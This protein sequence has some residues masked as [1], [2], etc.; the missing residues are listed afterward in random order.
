VNGLS[1]SSGGTFMAFNGSDNFTID[2]LD[3]DGNRA[4]RSCALFS[5][6]GGEHG[7]SV[8]IRSSRNGTIRNA[9][10]I[11]GCHDNV[12]LAGS[13]ASD[14]TTFP[15]NIN[16]IDSKFSNAFRN[17]VS[18]IEGWEIRF[19]GTCSGTF[20]GTCT[21]QMT[22]ANGGSPEAGIDWEPNPNSSASPSNANGMVDGCLISGNR[23]AGYQNHTVNGACNLTLQNSILRNNRSIQPQAPGTLIQN[24]YIRTSAGD[25]APRFG[26]IYMSRGQTSGSCVGTTTSAGRKSEVKDNFIDGD[27]IPGTDSGQDHIIYFGNFGDGTGEFKNNVATNSGETASGDWCRSGVA[28]GG[29][30]TVSGNTINGSTQSPNPGCP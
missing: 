19:L 6:G 14:T 20:S 16:F 18:V 8:Q 24:N 15:K 27:I 1:G 22:N 17:N 26:L 7:D 25:P 11:N 10:W 29:G 12:R 13:P 28:G 5:G 4:N 9:D 21:C 23:G 2:N 30:S 3:V